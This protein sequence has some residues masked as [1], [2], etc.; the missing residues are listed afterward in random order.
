MNAAA[1]NR[2]MCRIVT[3]TDVGPQPSSVTVA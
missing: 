1:H 3:G 2:F